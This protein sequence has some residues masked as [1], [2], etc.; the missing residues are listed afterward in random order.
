MTMTTTVVVAA[1]QYGVEF[2]GTWEAYTAKITWMVED[3]AAQ[4][5]RMLLFP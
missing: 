2:V 1:A 5:A 3:A 4:G